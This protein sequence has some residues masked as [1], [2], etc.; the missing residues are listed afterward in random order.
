MV[1]K[2]GNRFS[3]KTM[4]K[5][6][7]NRPQNSRANTSLGTLAMTQTKPR[8]NKP[9]TTTSARTP[10]API[11]MV[12]NASAMFLNACR[13]LLRSLTTSTTTTASAITPT[14]TFHAGRLPHDMLKADSIWLQDQTHSLS[15][16]RSTQVTP[17]NMT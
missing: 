14:T 8:E 9:A 10:T 3:D 16:V 2:S 6:K 12:Q 17:C 1:P 5:Q 7:S 11:T 13:L 15:M 4:L